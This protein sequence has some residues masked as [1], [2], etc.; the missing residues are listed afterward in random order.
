M[1]DNI[2]T[3]NDISEILNIPAPASNDNSLKTWFINSILTLLS[4]LVKK[5][6]LKND[7]IT[8]KIMPSDYENINTG[9]LINN[10]FYQMNHILWEKNILSDDDIKQI[11]TSDSNYSFIKTQNILTRVVDILSKKDLETINFL[12]ARNRT[13]RKT[14]IKT[15]I[16]ELAKITSEVNN[17]KIEYS[18]VQDKINVLIKNIKLGL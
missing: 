10:V 13:T 2:L 11:P 1:T 8:T 3:S 17:N 12:K 15:N 14:D 4:K 7:E 18:K 5:G 16:N 6:I 9:S